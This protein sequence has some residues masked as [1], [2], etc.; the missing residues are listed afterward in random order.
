M[1]AATSE[2][3]ASERARSRASKQAS[4]PASQPASK[5]ANNRQLG[6]FSSSVR[7]NKWLPW[8]SSSALCKSTI[9]LERAR[10]SLLANSFSQA[11]ASTA[12]VS[13]CLYQANLNLA[14]SYLSLFISLFLPHFLD[15]ELLLTLI[16]HL[17]G[18]MEQT[19]FISG[20]MGRHERIDGH[21][22]CNLVLGLRRGHPSEHGRT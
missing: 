6:Y 13:R 21:L 14:D 9:L 8:R 15:R 3:R 4:Q 20:L 5:L 12:D 7:A 10:R 19:S 16:Y 18:P 1:Q 2:K 17:Q 11:S 22:D